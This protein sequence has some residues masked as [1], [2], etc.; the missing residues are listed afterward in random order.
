MGI[1][2]EVGREANGD[3]IWRE[4][5]TADSAIVVGINL[6]LFDGKEVI[7]EYPDGKWYSWEK[8]K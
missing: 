2:L 6:K 1:K 8:T 5:S 3:P 4:H 7:A